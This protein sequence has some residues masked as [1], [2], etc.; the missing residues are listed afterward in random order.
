MRRLVAVVCF[1]FIAS[2]AQASSSV[3]VYVSFSMPEKL[4]RETASEAEVLGVPLLLNGLH[5]NSMT[6]TLDKLF[7]LSK[8]YP[9]LSD[10]IDPKRV[11]YVWRQLMRD[12]GYPLLF[13][14]SNH[15]L[16]RSVDPGRNYWL[17]N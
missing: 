9:R 1:S 2:L 4:L 8:K 3:S 7:E 15:F 5:H 12:N 14:L 13:R 6:Q 10:Q 11:F 17:F 16:M